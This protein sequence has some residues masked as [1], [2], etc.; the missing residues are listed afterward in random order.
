MRDSMIE[1]DHLKNE[2]A[3]IEDGDEDVFGD[4][5]MD[6][7]AK[8]ATKIQAGFRGQK[9]RTQVKEMRHS[10]AMGEH[11]PGEVVNKGTGEIPDDYNKANLKSEGQ[12]EKKK[13]KS[14]RMKMDENGNDISDDYKSFIEGNTDKLTQAAKRLQRSYRLRL[15]KKDMIRTIMVIIAEEERELLMNKETDDYKG[16]MEANAAATKIQAGFRGQQARKQVQE[17]KSNQVPNTEEVTINPISES[18]E[19]IEDYTD[20]EM[21]VSEASANAP[22]RNKKKPFTVIKRLLRHKDDQVFFLLHE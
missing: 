9:A 21:S 15:F 16:D 20:S 18:T 8:A 1:G 11:I 13:R 22:I 19:S 4:D 6:E 3:G 7:K 17:M 12:Q 2:V 5:G 14:V 10:I